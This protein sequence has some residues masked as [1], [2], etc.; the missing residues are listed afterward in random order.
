[1]AE[2]SNTPLAKKLG[3]RDG[4]RVLLR[5]PPSGFAG[6]LKPLPPRVQIMERARHPVDVIILFARQ[7]AEVRAAL[8]TAIGRLKRDG[9]LWIVWPKKTSGLT[10]D[11]DFDKVQKTGLKVGLVD[12]KICAI[13]LTWSGLRFVYRNEDR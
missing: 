10:T 9:G 5:N 2:Y 11:L 13:D 7:M 4:S 12:N 1:M 3:V 8:P 6:S